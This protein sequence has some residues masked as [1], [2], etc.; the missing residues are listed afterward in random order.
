MSLVRVIV[1]FSLMAPAWSQTP[2]TFVDGPVLTTASLMAA[3]AKKMDVVAGQQP[4]SSGGFTVGQRLT[5]AELN[6]VLA[7]KT[8]A[9]AGAQSTGTFTNPCPA[10]NQAE[11]CLTAAELNTVLA[12]KIDYPP[13]M[14]VTYEQYGAV[15]DCVAEDT[16]AIWNA[17]SGLRALQDK[18]TPVPVALTIN[19]N[20][21]SCYYYTDNRIF[22]GLKNLTLHGNNATMQLKY[23][24][25]Y[26]Q[27]VAAGSFI[28]NSQYQIYF[29]GTTDF[30]LI[31]SANNTVGTT[32]TA[33]GPGSGTGYATPIT[34]P[35][36]GGT[37]TWNATTGL[38]SLVWT[39]ANPVG[40][41]V[42]GAYQLITNRSFIEA[43]PLTGNIGFQARAKPYGPYIQSVS[44]GS[45]VTTIVPSGA[46]PAVFPPGQWALVTS[47]AMEGPN[48]YPINARYWDYVK[49]VSADPTTGVIQL[50]RP[51]TRTHVS[52]NFSVPTSSSLNFGMGPAKIIALGDPLN[53]QSPSVPFADSLAMDNVTFAV[54]P[55][56][57]RTSDISG[58]PNPTYGSDSP[59]NLEWIHSHNYFQP[60][61][62]YNASF[63]NVTATFFVPSAVAN[64]SLLNSTFLGAEPDKIIDAI[65]ITNSTFQFEFGGCSAVKLLNVQNSTFRAYPV[66][67]ANLYT[68][69]VIN[70]TPQQGIFNNTTFIGEGLGVTH[71]NVSLNNNFSAPTVMTISNSTF[72]GNGVQNNPVGFGV[73][74]GF[75]A[76][77]ITTT[78]D[79]TN[80]IATSTTR[81]HIV[82]ADVTGSWQLLGAAVPGQNIT[83]STTSVTGTV[84]SIIGDGASGA[85]MDVSGV[86]IHA[87]D[88]LKV[89]DIQPNSVTL[90]GN[91]YN[92]YVM[93]P[94]V[95]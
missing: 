77:L 80:Y 26:V 65:N 13:T 25:T 89:W 1:F 27:L 52:T 67:T 56:S 53:S 70:C 15:G 76:G 71:P 32:F 81:L 30:T 33:T 92:N 85:F 48:T 40:R 50:D 4:Q 35:S 23:P 82:N 8:D 78:I 41:G 66:G 59:N 12:S 60:A 61:G 44:G 51:L 88:V 93:G 68:H 34:T 47:Y 55:Y 45:S 62:V 14:S 9:P 79:G 18:L 63:T 49:I 37:Y 74:V 91:T 2:G 64:V 90:T 22:W 75:G 29:V 20:A 10:P 94:V 58:G 73:T 5:A 24:A 83:N 16:Q 39:G 69:G 19:L 6:A 87:A 11:F 43:T 7:K 84:T 54:N 57:G 72:N 38:Q 36:E 21:G 31:G 28:T 46:D 86:T 95:P 42:F 17:R 3:L